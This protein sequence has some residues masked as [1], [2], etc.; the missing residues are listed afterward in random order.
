MSNESKNSDMRKQQSCTLG[1]NLSFSQQ[2][3]I[4]LGD[5]TSTVPPRRVVEQSSEPPSKPIIKPSEKKH[6]TLRSHILSPSMAP[7][8]SSKKL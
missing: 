4:D 3:D 8:I 2:K 5:L 1:G 7:P 6:S